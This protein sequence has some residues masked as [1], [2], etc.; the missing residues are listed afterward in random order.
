M[1]LVTSFKE[2]LESLEALIEEFLK[3]LGSVK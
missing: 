3:D 1:E 2:I